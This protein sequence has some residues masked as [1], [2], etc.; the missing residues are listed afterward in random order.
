MTPEN[1][2]Q[3]LIDSV[4]AR[5]WLGGIFI[6][7][8]FIVG[9]YIMLNLFLAILLSNFDKQKR[10]TE[11]EEQGLMENAGDDPNDPDNAEKR[12]HKP[13]GNGSAQKSE[14]STPEKDKGS[15]DGHKRNSSEITN[16]GQIPK[17]LDVAAGLA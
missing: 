11:A 5:G 3:V 10:V 7:T 8:L 17:P 1:W 16:P 9:N 4:R 2:N 12:K 6:V 15:Q 13:G 14:K